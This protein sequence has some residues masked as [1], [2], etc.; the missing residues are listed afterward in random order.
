MPVVPIDLTIANLIPAGTYTGVVNK[1]TYQIKTGEKWNKEGTSDVSFDEFNNF[2]DDKR[3][4]H[5]N[6]KIPGKGGLFHDVYLMESARG[7]AQAFYNACGTSMTKAGFDPEACI[8]N[9]IGITVTVEDR[10]GYGPS[11]NLAFYKI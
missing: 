5:Y 10:P 1:V 8:G 4:L 2:S 3:R 7:F 11:N 6:L 9:Q